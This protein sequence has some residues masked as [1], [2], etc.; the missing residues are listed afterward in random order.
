MSGNSSISIFL[1]IRKFL[2]DYLIGMRRSSPHTI[3]EHKTL[4][5]TFVMFMAQQCNIK[6]SQLSLEHLTVQNVEAFLVWMMEKQ[7][8]SA[9]SVNLKLR[10]IKSFCSFVITQ[11]IQYIDK[12]LEIKRIKKLREPVEPV[13]FL[14]EEQMSLFISL[15]DTSSKKG[16]RDRLLI[17]IMYETGARLS[18]VSR[19]KYSDFIHENG[20]GACHLLGKGKKHRVVP[21][22]SKVLSHIECFKKMQKA[23]DDSYIFKSP[24]NSGGPLSASAIYKIISGYGYQ[25]S[26]LSNGAIACVHP[27]MLRHTMAMHLYHKGVA[28]EFISQLLGHSSVDTTSIYAFADT[29]MKRQAIEGAL[30]DQI[31]NIKSEGNELWRDEEKILKLASLK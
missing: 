27:H 9:S 8:N 5:R 16:L 31:P 12:M 20:G 7:G 19:L 29:Q 30:D 10:L 2:N 18:E 28:L 6:L 15:P 26:K 21:V 22:S 17:I 25:L 11:E 3:R 1:I 14:S 4:L 23:H 13:E 24:S